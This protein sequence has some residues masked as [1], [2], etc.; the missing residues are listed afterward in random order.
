MNAR[1]PGSA[2]TLAGLALILFPLLGL[3]A[4]FVYPGWMLV[5]AI[6]YGWM[7][8]PGYI[9]QI[10]VA[11]TGLL[12]KDGVLRRARGAWRTITAAW[13]TSIGILGVGFFLIDGG[14]DGRS[15]SAMTVLFG[16]TDSP[17][18]K[19][20]S[21]TFALVFG[22]LW[23]VGWAYLVIEWIIQLVIARRARKTG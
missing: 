20:L 11:A 19:D 13:V 21:M 12:R 4:K 23:L 5:I 15:E 18:A 3:A 6:W 8:L 7:L 22:V 10:V 17:D 14:D 9:V 2:A 16:M 1:K